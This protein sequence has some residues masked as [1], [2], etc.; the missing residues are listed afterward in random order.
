LGRILNCLRLILIP[1]S[2]LY[3]LFIA[4][5]T[6]AYKHRWLRVYQ[7]DVPVVCIGN[8]TWGGTGKT[9]LVMHIARQLI[10]RGIKVGIVSHGY[11]SKSREPLLVSDGTNILCS[12]DQC[13]DEPMMIARGL[14]PYRI[15]VAVGKNR[16]HAAKELINTKPVDMIVL[17]DGFQHL[18]LVRDLDI[19]CL[20]PERSFHNRLL[21]PAGNLREP[22]SSLRRA[23]YH[24]VIGSTASQ[25]ALEAAR[26]IEGFYE[27]KDNSLIL[28]GRIFI[29]CAI[30][31]PENFLKDLRALNL[32]IVGRCFFRDHHR[33]SAHDLAKITRE[34]LRYQANYIIITQKDAVRL[35]DMTIPSDIPWIVAKSYLAEK[36]DWSKFWDEI[37]SLVKAS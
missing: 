16:A 25:S 1:I 7:L 8:V 24:V 13:G 9:S 14:L 21:I 29:C 31:N 5:R 22:I 36:G 6:F 3:R 19:V 15:P 34:A 20:N 33:F 37:T 26:V 2:W 27:L 28:G 11:L 30:G 17:D 23:Q 4:I 35:S 10:V 32:D 12:W 18:A